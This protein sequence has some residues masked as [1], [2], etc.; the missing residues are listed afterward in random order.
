MAIIWAH[1]IYYFVLPHGNP[2]VHLEYQNK[3]YYTSASL[4]THLQ[5]K[6]KHKKNSEKWTLGCWSRLHINIEAWW[7]FIGGM[8][9]L[10]SN[11]KRSLMYMHFWKTCNFAND[12]FNQ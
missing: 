4:G 10:D 3:K 9:L 1:L 7:K 11:Y 8:C 5:I 6:R 2:G 12:N